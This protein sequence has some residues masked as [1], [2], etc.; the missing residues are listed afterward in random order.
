MQTDKGGGGGG[1]WPSGEPKLSVEN[2]SFLI[3]G[4]PYPT[5]PMFI[6]NIDDN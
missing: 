2:P 6:M 5:H 3:N 1:H 4:K